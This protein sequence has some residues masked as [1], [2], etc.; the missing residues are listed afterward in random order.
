M[1]PQLHILT[2][3]FWDLLK[4]FFAAM[5]EFRSVYDAYEAKVLYYADHHGVDRR[6]LRLTGEEVAGLFDFKR[7]EQLSDRH[8]ARVKEIS[9]RIFR[10]EDKTDSFDRYASQIY[11]ELSILKE[12]QYKVSTFAPAYKQQEDEFA[13]QS[14][15]DEAHEAFPRAIQA[16]DALFRRAHERLERLLPHF[17]H[18]KRVL[19]SAY[20]FGD[21]VFGEVYP[22]GYE[23]V[24]ALMFPG[25]G[26]A[27]GLIEV[28]QSFHASGFVESAIE[29]LEKIGRLPPPRQLERGTF[30]ELQEQ[31]SL[32]LT[33]YKDAK[34]KRRKGR[35]PTA[36]AAATT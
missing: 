36:I 27:R 7:L 34:N 33:S 20:L 17:A 13:Y 29:A 19:R 16:I 9:H 23:E 31:S 21:Q 11:H 5:N 25:G 24:L 32:L 8:M 2:G 28:A 35:K 15:V 30:D 6:L 14:I 26:T 22:D 12:E 1:R 3:S 4:A 10:S 18:D